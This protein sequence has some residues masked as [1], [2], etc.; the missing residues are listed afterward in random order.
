MPY[1]SLIDRPDDAVVGGFVVYIID[2]DPQT[3][4]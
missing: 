4:G 2:H 3:D 1:M